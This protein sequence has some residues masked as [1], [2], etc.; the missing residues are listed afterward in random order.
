MDAPKVSVVLP[1]R[2]AGRYLAGAIS[3]TLNQTYSKLEVVV[4]DDGTTDGSIDAARGCSDARMKVVANAGKGLVD[5]LNTG[6]AVARGDYIARMDADDLALPNRIESS[7]SALDQNKDVGLVA[8]RAELIDA[9]DNHIRMSPRLPSDH[10]LILE[11]LLYKRRV[12]P[13]IHPSVMFRRGL[14]VEIGG[15]RAIAA[16]EDHD[17]WLR[18]LDRSKFLFVDEI[19]LK[20][21]IH[22]GGV[23][24]LQSAEQ[25]AGAILSAVLHEAAVQVGVDLLKACPELVS[26]LR[27][28]I[29]S[30]SA[31]S[32]RHRLAS[33]ELRERLTVLRSGRT[34]QVRQLAR[35]ALSAV[36][37]RLAAT[38]TQRRIV[39]RA[40][41]VACALVPVPTEQRL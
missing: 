20:Y 25:S 41:N 12:P 3:S 17:M 37:W 4:V 40:S 31:S 33:R 21:R 6:I 18:M 9:N 13:I 32:L 30:E 35:S 19:L 2:N 36:Y 15:Y 10:R 27:E 14:A 38:R 26:A 22:A 11:G 34:D 5:A 8:T 29:Q 39:V 7:V 1:A 24:A 28:L 16:A 23:S